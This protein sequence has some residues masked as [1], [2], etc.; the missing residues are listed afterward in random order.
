MITA[1][2]HG[3]NVFSAARQLGFPPE[4]ILDFSASINPLGPAPGVRKAIADAFK[5]VPNYPESGSPALCSALADYLSLPADHIAVAN[6]ST[7]LIHLLPRLFRRATGR[8]LLLAPTF[9][10]YG[11]AL[12][13]AGWH[14]TCLPL[15]HA[16][17]FALD[18][19]AI[20]GELAKGYDLFIICN[21]GNPTGTLYP[22]DEIETLYRFCRSSGCF[23]VIDEAFSDFTDNSSA[24]YLIPSTDSGL[25]LRS[26][27]KFFGFPGIRV[28]YSIA[29]AAVTARLKRF[30]PPWNVSVVAQA[31][32]L[33]G[34]ADRGHCQRTLALI[35]KERRYLADSLARLKGLTVYD[36][37]ANYLLV[38]LDNGLTAAGLQEQLLKELILIRDCS[39]FDG[40]D[41]RFFRVAVKGRA[42]NKK[43]LQAIAGAVNL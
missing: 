26:M 33:A 29:S 11:N 22:L 15:D 10:E 6:G 12:E 36:G 30:L 38:R 25:I 23:F 21:P 17:G 7:E 3:G 28:G 18:T 19:G 27:T 35:E 20:A 32:A 2:H 9:A 37:A 43:L 40:L 1:Y 34:L 5:H 8:A 14:C 13:L 42:D 24:Q 16:T 41:E 4:A 31:A 39:D